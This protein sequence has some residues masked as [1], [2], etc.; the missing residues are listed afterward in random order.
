[1]RE[2]RTAF[3]AGALTAIC[4]Y[5][6]VWGGDSLLEV[7][8]YRPVFN[9]ETFFDH[10]RRFLNEIL[11][12]NVLISREMTLAIWV[13]LLAV[14]WFSK[15]PHLRFCWLFNLLSTLPIVFLPTRSGASLFVP[16]MGWS[17]FA[18]TLA[19]GV[20]DFLA[21]RYPFRLLPSPSAQIALT[22]PLVLALGYKTETEKSGALPHFQE[23]QAL[24]WHV[25]QQFQARKPVF[26]RKSNVI[27]LH[28]PFEGW[29]MI[30]IAKLYSLD[31]SVRFILARLQLPRPTEQDLAEFDYVFDYQDDKLLQLKPR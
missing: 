24:N 4:V 10:N 21:R 5:S 13:L 18:A 19:W 12:I 29:D 11:C 17:I 20:I 2:G 28:D 9:L 8:N 25:I 15:W 31:P 23:A 22:L 14:A 16:F 26:S 30:F 6:K 7:A 27:F 3:A 1:M